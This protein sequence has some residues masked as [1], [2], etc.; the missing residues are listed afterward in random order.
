MSNIILFAIALAGVG[1]DASSWGVFYKS[2]SKSVYSR[3]QQHCTTDSLVPHFTAA[4]DAT[5]TEPW[6]VTIAVDFSSRRMWMS[7]NAESA[8]LAF[9][10]F[11]LSGAALTPAF[12][13][14][15]TC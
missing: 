1:D 11:E 12:S 13:A 5:P 2:G 10:G 3:W 4:K 7:I 6:V 14:Q 15:G 9:D 8:I